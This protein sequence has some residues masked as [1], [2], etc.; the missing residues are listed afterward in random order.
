MT[1]GVENMTR[2]KLFVAMAALAGTLVLG[3][4]PAAAE[5]ATTPVNVR[6]G[7]GTGYG[8]VDVLARGE[9]VDVTRR[10]GGWCYV[11]RPGPDGWVSCRYLTDSGLPGGT[12][13]RPDVSIEFTIPG[14]SFSIGD[15]RF[16]FD[17]P[18]R[19]DRRSQVCFYEHVN[20]EGDR[21]CARPGE[22]IRALGA[23][24][25]RI[26]SIRV[27]GDAEA[28]VCEHNNFRGR[29]ALI[30]RNVRNLGR[31]GNDII[32]SIRVR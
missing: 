13:G 17:R 21:F 8:V 30:D 1:Q 23:W 24:N 32:S 3:A 31:R 28:Q 11:Q 7:P 26:S 15:G 25:D 27:R 2:N 16:D 14:F 22:R 12:A 9:R 5:Q 18:R 4:A 20:Y 10:T 6:G 19:P 29:C